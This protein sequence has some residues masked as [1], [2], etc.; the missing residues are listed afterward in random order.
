MA[1]SRKA[2]GPPLE[3]ALERGEKFFQK[4]NFPLAQRELEAALGLGVSEAQARE[5]SDKLEV[6]AREVALLEGREAIK[7]ARKLEKKGQYRDAL[8]QFE[9]ALVIEHEDWIEERIAALR[10]ALSQAEAADLLDAVAEDEDP[11]VRLAAYDKALT[12]G[13]DPA[14][15]EQRANC[16]VE[17][18]RFDE[19]IA[20]YAAAP[21]SSDL[22][23]YR[24]GYACAAVGRYLDALAAWRGIEAGS[25]G[26]AG[27]VEQ[28]LP[29]ACREAER[30]AS[31]ATRADGYAIITE[32]AHRID[33]AEK[34]ARLEAWEAHATCSQLDALWEEER[35]DEMVPLLP[36]LG[37]PPDRA[38]LAMHAKVSF[39]RAERDAEHLESAVGLWLTAVYDDD[40]LDALTVHGAASAPLDRQAVRDRLVERLGALVAGHAKQGRLSPRVQGIWRM[41]ER[42]IRQLSGLPVQGVPPACYPCTPGFALHHGLADAIFAFLDAQPS[43]PPDSG[44]DLLELRA[45]FG[46]TGEAMMWMEAGEEERALAAIPRDID[47]DLVRYCRERIALACG[48]A[49]ARRG[50]PQIKRYFLDALPLLQAEPKRAQEIL[51]LAY[52]DKPSAFFEGLADA[53]E[54]LCGRLDHPDLPQAAAHA[55]GIKAVAMLNRGINPAIAQKLLERALEIFPESELA[56]STLDALEERRIGKDIEKAFKRQNSL[57]AA[58]LVLTSNDPGNRDFFFENM[59]LWYHQAQQMERP[60]RA[61]LLAEVH[62]SCRLVDVSHSLTR[63]VAD[64]ISELKSH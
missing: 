56:G 17:L 30:S 12:T 55:M 40:L 51:G 52:A 9:K 58:K 38:A 42:I 26:L 16:L 45:C 25:Q 36:S 13:A 63:K 57:R 14:V 23:R 20:Q 5:I 1:K 31:C 2:K 37:Q 22:S 33:P 34:S 28:L 48:M 41:D 15:A 19:A 61:A 46:A 32:M 47:N 6:C 21:L 49:K 53:L 43:P 4:G 54:A 35:F 3:L 29:F 62:E 27:Q 18:E 60:M 50:E 44:I 10:L 7:R 39:K 59:E 64:A 8:E 24:Q 11:Q